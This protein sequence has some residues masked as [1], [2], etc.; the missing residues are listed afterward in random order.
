MLSLLSLAGPWP[1]GSAAA[2]AN[3]LAFL[4]PWFRPIDE[5]RET[6]ARRGVVVRALPAKDRQIAI[7]ATCAINVSPDAFVTRL[8]A[9][10]DIDNRAL[11]A[12]RFTDP[13]VIGD[14]A[15]LSLD[16]EDVDRLRRCRIGDCRLNLGNEEISAV[17]A[18][19]TKPADGPEAAVQQVFRN[20]VLDRARRYQAGGLEALPDYYDR[21]DPVRPA[22][23]F[24]EILKQSA[25]LQEHLPRLAA[26]LQRSPSTDVAPLASF[27]HWSRVMMNGKAV[28]RVSHI[29][30]FRP[31][32]GP[33]TPA[34]VVAGKQVYASRYMNGE[35]TLTMLFAR[36]DGTSSYLVHVDRSELDELG[37]AF[38]G[39]KRRLMSERIKGEAT[40]ALAALR[41]RL[42]HAR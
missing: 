22:L 19:L 10:W 8:R 40:G 31:D 37:G 9:A 23:V 12:G 17:R 1:H 39:V 36:T 24:A 33:R 18:A 27:L 4:E 15:R 34:V 11:A 38:S 28:V 14:I 6:L 13:P 5:E 2:P 25:Y 35:L 26:Y 29:S 32:G 16:E 30:V 3:D 41:D 20:V 42:E 21:R 7:L